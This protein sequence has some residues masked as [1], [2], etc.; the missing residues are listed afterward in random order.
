[1]NTSGLS[2]RHAERMERAHCFRDEFPDLVE[3]AVARYLA[4]LEVRRAENVRAVSA[5]VR[6][7]EEGSARVVELE[8]G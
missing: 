8:T 4:W 1:M 5:M 3:Y 6:W 7:E 2:E